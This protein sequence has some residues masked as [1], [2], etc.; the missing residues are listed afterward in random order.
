M[1]TSAAVAAQMFA[2]GAYNA[3]L[4]LFAK[5]VAGLDAGKIGLIFGI[6]TTT[7]L[8][9]RPLM[10]RASDRIGRKPLILAALFW[11]A[12]LI[13]LLPHVQRF[14]L[15]LIF[16]SAWGLGSAVVSSVASAFIT[17]LAKRAHYG[18]AH[19]AFGTIFDIGEATG[20]IV[21]GMLVASVGYAW[22]FLV[23]AIQLT[24]MAALFAATGFENY[25]R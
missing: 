24:V 22:M 17:D 13:A 21:A 23:V 7:T 9:A 5:D 25:R 6:Q 11:C 3:F 18:A 20:P 16:G 8:L 12:L 2:A 14:E 4:P 1:I 10:G 15:L 19:G